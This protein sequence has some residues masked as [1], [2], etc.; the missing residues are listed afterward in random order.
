MI[1]VWDPDVLLGPKTQ[2]HC[3]RKGSCLFAYLIYFDFTIC[4]VNGQSLQRFSCDAKKVSKIV[5]YLVSSYGMKVKVFNGIEM[6]T[7][8]G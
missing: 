8:N 7:Y 4:V 6:Y 2:S 5:P 3:P 1:P